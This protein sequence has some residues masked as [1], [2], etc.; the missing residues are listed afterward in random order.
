MNNFHPYWCMLLGDQSD[1]RVSRRACYAIH[2]ALRIV[3]TLGYD[4][5][6]IKPYGQVYQTRIYA[7]V[8]LALRNGE[9]ELT[10]A[11][12]YA[13]LLLHHQKDAILKRCDGWD[14]YRWALYLEK[15]GK[16][17]SNYR[18]IL[19]RDLL[20]SPVHQRDPGFKLTSHPI[21][22]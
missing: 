22:V 1:K 18:W 11:V 17:R 14:I 13:A 2:R 7:G 12:E 3:S 4:I 21:V 20:P 8:R 15:T 19:Q 9:D 5:E 16:M 10:T 6:D